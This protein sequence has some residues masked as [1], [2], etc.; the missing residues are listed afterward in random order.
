MLTVLINGQKA[1]GKDYS[2]SDTF[3]YYKMK[4]DGKYTANQILKAVDIYT[5]RKNDIPAPADI[6]QIINPL[7]A[8]ITYAEYKHA[9]EQHKLEGFPCFGYYGVLIKDYE[10]QENLTNETP[11]N[12]ELLESRNQ[13]L[14][15][16]VKQ[17][18]A[19]T[20]G[21]KNGR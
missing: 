12:Y 2:V 18:L 13:E 21:G 1:Y 3:S 17:I 9:L 11:S 16:N 14:P 5:D 19:V 7:P 4:L 6:I 8:K 10:K 20:Y 15:D